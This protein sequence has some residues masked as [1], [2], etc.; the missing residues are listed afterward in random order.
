MVSVQKVPYAA[1]SRV[2]M[3]QEQVGTESGVLSLTKSDHKTQTKLD[4]ARRSRRTEPR[5]YYLLLFASVFFIPC[6]NRKLS[7]TASTTPVSK[8]WQKYWQRN[9]RPIYSVQLRHMETTTPQMK[10]SRHSF[11]SSVT[12]P[13]LTLNLQ[14]VS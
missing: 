2:T 13:P 11:T 9:H 6:A 14:P 4:K 8:Q 7:A 3:K 1:E 5:S 10:S 12:I